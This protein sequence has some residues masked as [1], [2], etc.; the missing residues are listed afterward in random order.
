[1]IHKECKICDG[2]YQKIP[3]II[4][5]KQEESW[6]EEYKGAVFAYS[7]FAGLTVFILIP[8]ITGIVMWIK[9]IFF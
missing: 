2:G 1:M 6:W 8:W 5:D 3:I 7:I 9:W 4:E